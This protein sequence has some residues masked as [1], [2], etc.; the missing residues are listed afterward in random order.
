[1]G[2]HSGFIA[3]HAT[4][5]TSNV[6]FCLVPE[7]PFSLDGEN[8]FLAAL[9][10]RLLRK[11]HAVVVVGEGAGQYLLEASNSQET[12]A[13]GNIRFKDIGTF[14]T[15]RIKDHFQARNL[16]L[17]IKYIDPSY[18]IRSLPA[19]AVD[20][21]FCVVLGQCAVHAA[22]AGKTNMVVGVWNQHFTH[23][24]IPVVVKARKQLDL[25]GEHWQAVLGTTHQPSWQE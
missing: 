8:G 12:D 13:S 25:A 20:S 3:A 17:T 19:N 4:L 5:A 16:P 23:I 9:E 10:K 7:V 11:R 22:M 21:E 6:N 18:T 2:R 15:N 14:L 1:M 24:P